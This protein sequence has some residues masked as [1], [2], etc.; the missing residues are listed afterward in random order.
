MGPQ[1]ARGAAPPRILER[2]RNTS[3]CKVDRGGSSIPGGGLRWSGVQFGIQLD[4]ALRR[5]LVHVTGLHGISMFT[6]GREHEKKCAVAYIRNPQQAALISNVIDSVHDLL[7]GTASVEKVSDTIRTAFAQGGSGVWERAGSWLR[8]T[9]AHDPSLVS[10][11]DELATHPKAEVRFRVACF[12]DQVPTSSFAVLS[13]L[14]AVDK[15]K[16]VSSM[17]TARIEEVDARGQE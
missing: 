7:E 3:L 10:L 11:W 16:R 12:L 9:S 14:L 13:Q 1:Y 6:F 2:S 17:A 5:G 15:S 8:K 4:A